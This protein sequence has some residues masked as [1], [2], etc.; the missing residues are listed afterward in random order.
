[1]STQTARDQAMADLAV[2]VEAVKH[3]TTQGSEA[4]ERVAALEDGAGTFL[5]EQPD[6]LDNLSA[7][8]AAARERVGLADQALA[9]ATGEERD[10]RH[11]VARAA[12][13]EVQPVI[14]ALQERL[15]AHEERT[16][17]LV[18]ALEEHAGGR[19]Q[20]RSVA[21]ARPD[22][23]PGFLGAV[24]LV[25][26]APLVAD[27]MRADIATATRRRDMINHVAEGGKIAE[28]WPSVPVVQWPPEVR[29]GGVLEQESANGGLFGRIWA[30]ARQ[31]HA[32]GTPV[33]EVN[34]AAT[35]LEAARERLA[36]A[37]DAGWVEEAARRREL[38]VSADAAHTTAVFQKEENERHVARADAAA[39]EKEREQAE[40]DAAWSAI[41]ERAGVAA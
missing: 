15:D 2:Q 22:T 40:A 28:K 9:V 34:V 38:F 11:A 8:L 32:E 16:A 30:H 17:E 39:I 31:E 6:K 41:L 36:Q 12:A 4:Q 23:S 20:A 7:Q 10:A 27:D 18:A 13:A 29:L 21:D 25:N 1:M 26:W 33:R 24:R 5:A 14:D 35:R 37:E 3:W 19:W